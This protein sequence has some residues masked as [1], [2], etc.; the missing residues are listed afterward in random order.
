MTEPA[1]YVP[2][3]AQL[4][5]FYASNAFL[6]ALVGPVYAGRKTCVVND[7]VRRA[8]DRRYSRQGLWRWLVARP[9]RRGL[10]LYTI[11]CLK[12]WLPRGKGEWSPSGRGYALKYRLADG[13]VR[14]LEIECLGL[15]DPADR[16]RLAAGG[17]SAVWLDDARNLSEAVLEDAIR[18][19]GSEVGGGR[20]VWSGVVCS[21][22]MPAPGHWLLR[23]PEDPGDLALFRQPGGRAPEAENLAVLKKRGFAYDELAVE[24]D[25]DWVRVEIDAEIGFSASDQ[26]RE[27]ERH[28]ARSSLARWTGTAMPEI[29]PARHHQLL[30][31][32]LEALERGDITRLMFF[33][34]PGSAK[35]LALDTPLPTP[36]GWTTMGAVA[37]GDQVF[38]ENGRRCRVIRKSQVWRARPVYR[39]S[40][41][42]GDQIIA[43]EDHEWRVCLDRK[44][45]VFK[46]H[47]T[48]YLARP[49]NK[50]PMV[51]RALALDLP[52]IDLPIEPY[53]LGL[54]LGDGRSEGGTITKGVADLAWLAPEIERLGYR[55]TRRRQDTDLGVLGIRGEL[56]ELGLVNDPLHGVRGAK[57]I[58]PRYLRASPRQRLNLLQGLVDS[59]GHVAPGGMTVFSSTNPDLAAGVAELAR[60][61]GVKASIGES[62]AKLNGRDY[63]PYWRVYFYLAEAARL[64]R[65]AASA[66]NGTRTPNTYLS[67]EPWGRADTVCIEV[68]SPSH[69]FLAGTSMTPTH[70]STYGSVLFPSWYMGRNPAHNVIAASHAKE[71][72]ER[73]GRRVRNIEASEAFR[74][75]FGFGLSAGSAAAGRFETA[76]GGEYFAVGVDGSVTGRRA[77][78]GI[79]DDPI[80]GRAEADSP[81]VRQHAW[82]WY[83]SDFWTRLVPGAK[84]LYIGTRWHD[85]DLA[86]RLLDDAKSGGEQWRVVSVP[87]IAI[88]GREDP[89]GRMPGERLWPEWF[90][91]EMFEQAQ[92]DPRNWSALYQQEPMP[93]TGEYFKSE[94]LR[95]YDT[96][97]PR[98]QLRTYG[99]SDYAVSAAAGDFTAHL[100]V[101]VDPADDIY[102]LD[103]WR[104]RTASDA[105]AEALIDLMARWKTLTWAEERGQIE[106][107]VGPFLTKRQLERKVYAARRQFTSAHDKATRAQAIRGRLAMG[108]V[109]LPRRAP[110]TT[111]LV[112]ELLRFP[113]GRNDDMVDSLSLIG[114]MLDEL[115]PGSKPRAVEP[116]RG[117]ERMTWDECIRLTGPGGRF[118]HPL[119]GRLS[120]RI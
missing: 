31:D 16:R 42:C 73:F 13:V 12:A 95:W 79:I 101:G 72:A 118:G 102:L 99:A 69:L 38:D 115:I 80:K 94:W 106:K 81:T 40:T 23:R 58:P 37:V 32:H 65:K 18:A 68:D 120:A 76:R 10:E 87:A 98:E 92:R 61:L 41:D 75:T 70:N 55:T 114:R 62:R 67:V 111:D 53:V 4:R 103:L 104:E 27:A 7:I 6:R 15:D 59:D 1:R 71:L 97:P 86:G 56:V 85:D 66:R 107:G 14:R 22:R 3:G 35:A 117:A 33:L 57:A 108:K 77:H 52:E 63:G 43:D 112:N 109:L 64:P 28:A 48:A 26:A 47:K 84:L 90:T 88:E 46:V 60:S 20:L 51:A 54:W 45:G 30:I 50:R 100:V 93:E 25:P 105:W 91:A 78:L 96:A 113:A 11:P 36:S 119:G 8:T 82:D 9:T 24:R 110:W 49:R 34:P 74:D 89:L 39:V 5:A 19:A 21:S 2:D 44:W 116:I 29:A 17:A 83:K